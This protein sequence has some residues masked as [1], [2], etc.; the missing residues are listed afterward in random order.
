M[1]FGS[2]SSVKGLQNQSERYIDDC[3]D[4]ISNCWCTENG[5]NGRYFA[6]LNYLAKKI[7]LVPRS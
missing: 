2:S 5:K 3:C 7:K 1:D 6:Q 4:S